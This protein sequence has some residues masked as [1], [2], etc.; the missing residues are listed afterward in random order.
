[1]YTERFAH[2]RLSDYAS[3]TSLW[4]FGCFDNHLRKL[5]VTLTRRRKKNFK[6]K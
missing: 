2:W 6:N 5:P 1:M 4:T 3:N